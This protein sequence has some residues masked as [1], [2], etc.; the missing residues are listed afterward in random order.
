MKY[1]EIVL[2]ESSNE[3]IK[4]IAK[5]VKAKDLRFYPV[6]KDGMQ[7]SRMIVTDHYLQKA[8]NSFSHIMG[9]Q[10]TSKIIILPIEAYLP[11]NSEK[12]EKKEEKANASKEAIY[13]ELKKN[14][15]INSNFILLLVFSTIV[16]TIGLIHNNLAII[17]GAMVIAPLLG[18]NMAFSFAA[19]IGDGKLMYSSIKTILLGFFIAIML[20]LIF[21][22]FFGQNLDTYE[23]VSKTEV[24]YD[25][26]ILALASGAAASLSITAGLSSILVGVMVS[27]ALLPPA[28]VL[29][30]MIGSGNSEL[31]IGAGILLLIN[32]T[33]IN[34]ASKVIF[35]IK[36]IRPTLWDKKEIA[37]KS[38]T[39]YILSWLIILIIIFIYIYY[40]PSF[41]KSIF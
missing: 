29:G 38:M 15:N 22:L 27:A 31:A 17:I 10:V 33:S 21:A 34:L 20:P 13:N 32:I 3:I 14:S 18:P 2:N 16:A 5:N 28:A 9:D 41:L 30:L 35:L 40:K 19:S 39:I 26:F 23:L 4:Q 7:I 12:E 8:I 25:S 24:S 37:K 1:L 11:K 36:G 6:D